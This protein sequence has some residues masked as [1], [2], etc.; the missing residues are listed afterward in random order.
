[1]RH[2]PF[3]STPALTLSGQ[4]Q[5]VRLLSVSPL[6]GLTH[7]AG[8]PSGFS[9]TGTAGSGEGLFLL[10]SQAPGATDMSRGPES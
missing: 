3:Q 1:M 7:L 4:V 2:C 6:F 5:S 10:P 9:P 8:L